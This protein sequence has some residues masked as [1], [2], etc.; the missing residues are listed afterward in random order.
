LK[1]ST[2]GK[3][4]NDLY[5]LIFWFGEG[6]RDCDI[7]QGT[8]SEVAGVLENKQSSCKRSGIKRGTWLRALVVE[9]SEG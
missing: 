5:V 2:K 8:K 9:E 6:M 4:M 3:E 7:F 1:Q